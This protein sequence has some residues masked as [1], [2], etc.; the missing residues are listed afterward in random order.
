ME[1][2]YIIFKVGWLTQV[3]GNESRIE[4]IH[5]IV[6]SLLGY[7]Q[8]HQLVVQPILEIGEPI[9][10]ELK[11]MRSNLTDRGFRLYKQAEQ[12]WL[13]GIDRGRDPT[14]MGVFDRE[15]AKLDLAD[16]RCE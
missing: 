7:L 8:K 2:D 16:N 4:H 12:K 10:D 9:T 1:K 5:T 13:K 3:R 15:L 6:K 11:L 14:N